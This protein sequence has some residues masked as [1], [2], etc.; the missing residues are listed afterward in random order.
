MRIGEPSERTGA[1]TRALRHYESQGLLLPPRSA[2]R[3][4]DYH[5]SAITRVQ[6][7]RTLISAGL[8]T[9]TI[10]QVLPC[11]DLI[12]GQAVPCADLKSELQ[13]ERARLGRQLS[14]LSDSVQILDTVI[15][16][17]R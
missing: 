2:N 6:I 1:S 16:Q 5:E 10:L 12:G 8:T 9:K 14:D 4:R 17:A 7:I 13:Q 15:A 3:Y 11:V